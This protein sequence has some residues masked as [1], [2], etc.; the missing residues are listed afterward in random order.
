M[1]KCQ[2]RICNNFLSEEV[3]GN[4]GYCIGPENDPDKCLND[5][6][7]FQRLERN[8][9]RKRKLELLTTLKNITL[10]ANSFKSITV[11]RFRHL[12]YPYVDLLELRYYKGMAIQYFEGFELTK[13]EVDNTIYI[14][15]S[16]TIQ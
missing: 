12:I 15:I 13:H 5:E 6:K 16:K 1:K 10:G 3:H 4:R 14:H 8:E 11:D 9:K 2:S 7:E